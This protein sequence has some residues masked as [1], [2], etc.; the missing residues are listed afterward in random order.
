MTINRQGVRMKVVHRKTD[1]V[2][3]RSELLS[4]YFLPGFLVRG[5]VDFTVKL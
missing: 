4:Q 5:K 1:T 2:C 3:N